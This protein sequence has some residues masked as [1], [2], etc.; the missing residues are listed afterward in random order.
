M[1][2]YCS[3]KFS[4]SSNFIVTSACSSSSIRFRK[5]MSGSRVDDGCDALLFIAMMPSCGVG[6]II[7]ISVIFVFL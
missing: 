4:V 3:F 1:L 7:K 2:T 6:V 5:T